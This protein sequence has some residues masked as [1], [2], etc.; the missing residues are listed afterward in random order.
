VGFEQADYLSWYMPRAFRGDGAVNLHASGVAQV[1]PGQLDPPQVPVAEAV[2]RLEAA[3]AR[4][5][6]AAPEEIVFTPGATGGTL[7]AL[8]TLAPAGGGLAVERPIYEPMLRQAMRLGA[9]GRLD[10]P[11][12]RGFQLDLDR[13]ATLIDDRTA[14]AMITEPHNPGG[15]LSPRADV[16]ELARLLESRGAVLLINEVY[17]GFTDAPSCFGA[18]PNIVVVA[19]LS[20]LLGAY[21]ARVG[22][23]AAPPDLAARLRLAHMTMGM[24]SRPSAG[25]GLSFLERAEGLRAEARAL[26]AAGA[27]RVRRFVEETPGV[28]W[29]RPEG[30]GFACVALPEGTDDLRLA[31][32]LHD[33]DGVL[34]VPGRFFDLPG[35]LRLG[36]LQSGERVDEG[37][38]RLAERLSRRP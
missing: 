6:G 18:A 26:S 2:P 7:L 33:R 8:L 23:L 30:P 25:F 21:W 35:T 37:L 36:W 32:E 28:G 15:C 1:E 22:W 10:R 38:E 20:K 27:A 9:V 14:L 3:L 4:W 17:R 31:E 5:Q 12:D 34:T 11:F 24:P 16:L 13:A 19:S 29:V